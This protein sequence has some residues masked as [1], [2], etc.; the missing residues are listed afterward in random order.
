[1]PPR[2]LVVD[3]D[4][5]YLAGL[6][7]LLE[8]HGYEV[9]LAATFEAAQRALRYDAPDLL[10]AD[11]RLG[12]FNGLQLIAMGRVR[13]P[14]LVVSGFDDAVIQA[15]AKSFGAD[16]IVKPVDA[17]ALLGLIDQRLTT[18]AVRSPGAVA[19]P[20]DAAPSDPL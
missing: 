16:Y 18:S 20:L 12:P 10:I 3:D 7:E 11:V 15:D 6:K 2:I 13:I 8:L 14:T 17:A 1:M 5:A 9:L 4:E 19:P